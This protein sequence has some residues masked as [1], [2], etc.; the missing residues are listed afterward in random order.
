MLRGEQKPFKLA[1]V[2][3]YIQLKA[4]GENSIKKTQCSPVIQSHHNSP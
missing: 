4:E 2:E 1:Q 3:V